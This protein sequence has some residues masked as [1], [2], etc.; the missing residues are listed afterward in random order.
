MPDVISKSAYAARRGVATSAVSNWIARGKLTGA[1]LTADGQINAEEADR[2]LGQTVD[3]GRGAQAATPRPAAAADPVVAS[4]ADVRL[5]REQLSLD[6][7]RRQAAIDAGELVR[8]DDAKRAWAKELDDLI[9]AVELFVTE[10]PTKLGLGREAVEQA[11]REW[12]EFRRRRAD[13]AEAP[14]AA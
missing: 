14:R 7:A 9:S 2:Q 1:A 12:R 10:L 3:P 13:Q 11:R 4:L 8:A 5:Q 6:Q